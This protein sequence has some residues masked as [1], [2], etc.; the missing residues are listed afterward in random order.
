VRVGGRV[1]A[2]LRGRAVLDVTFGAQVEGI[3]WVDT[4]WFEGGLPTCHWNRA[5][6]GLAT[7]RQLRELGLAPGGAPPVAAL[8]R[9][10]AGRLHAYLYRLDLAV[11]KREATPAVLG[12]LGEAMRARRTCPTCGTDTGACLPRSLG[13]CWDCSLAAPARVR[14]APDHPGTETARGAAA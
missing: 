1:M 14:A 10:P 2:R 9:R 12:A 3:G 8:R 7:R 4:A 6:A 11:R 5:P 13:E